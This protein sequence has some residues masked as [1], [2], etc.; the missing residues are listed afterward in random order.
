MRSV[1]GLAVLIIS[2]AGGLAQERAKPAAAPKKAALTAE[3]VIDKS[4]EAAGGR[5]AMEKLVSTYAKGMM[6]FT[7]QDMYG[8]LE[9]YAKAPNKQLIVMNLDMVGEVKQA[10]DGKVAWAREPSGRIVE[11]S[12]APLEDARRRAVF[13]APLRW[14]ELYPKAELTGEDSVGD[15]KA[16][17]IRLTAATGQ[18]VTRYYDQETFLLLRE[19][20][21][22]DTPQGAMDVQADFSDYRDVDGVKTPFRITQT[23]P[24]GELVLK[25]S[26]VKNNLEID[27][28]KFRKPADK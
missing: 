12:G 16:Y 13:N 14:R 8:L 4:I 27:D 20:G 24:A 3:Q 23:L 7:E 5:A 11:V 9:L 25:I 21:N 22:H 15:R 28:A 6:E 18:F 26:E 2:A 19:A 1:L 17:V 10:F